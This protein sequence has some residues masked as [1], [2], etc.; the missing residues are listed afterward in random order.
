MTFHVLG[1]PAPQGSK[2]SVGHG[3]MI[4]SSNKVVPWREAVKWAAVAA[5]KEQGVS[6]LRVPA[7]VSIEFRLRRPKKPKFGWVPGVKPDLDKLIRSTLD[8]LTDSGVIADDA[9]VVWVGASKRWDTSHPMGA[10][11]AVVAA[12]KEPA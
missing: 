2:K 9:L 7:A 6:T 5:M 12:A 8:A 10:T 3:R 4:E 11:I 1:E